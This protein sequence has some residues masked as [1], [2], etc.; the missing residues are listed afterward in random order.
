MPQH[1]DL[2]IRGTIGIVV[3]A[4]E[5]EQIGHV[6]ELETCTAKLQAADL[7]PGRPDY[8]PG[9]LAADSCLLAHPP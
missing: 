4:V 3:H 7:R 1:K 2:R 6:P 9:F 8:I 5:A